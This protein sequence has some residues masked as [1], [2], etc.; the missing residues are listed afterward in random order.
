MV[1][2]CSSPSTDRVF[3]AFADRTRLRLLNLLRDGEKCVCVLVDVLRQPQ[4]TV[5][6]HLGHLRRAGL[7]QARKDGMWV[8]Y[9]LAEPATE[10]HQRLLECIE[11]CLADVP[12]LKRDGRRVQSAECRV[13]NRK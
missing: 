12:E 13:Q 11:C 3:G 6:R 4:P 1:R 2:T 8:H 10:L 5:S 9:R 7:V